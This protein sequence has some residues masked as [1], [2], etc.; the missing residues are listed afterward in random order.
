MKNKFMIKVN[1]FIAAVLVLYCFST[2]GQSEKIFPLGYNPVIKQA[3]SS[4]V[5]SASSNKTSVAND[6]LTLPFFDDFSSLTI[7]PD[8]QRWMDSLAFVN[9]NFP[10]NPPTLGVATFDGL[11]ANGNPYDN[12]STAAK[13]LCDELTSKP[14][15]LFKDE[16]GLPYNTSDSIFL[17]YYYQRK[18]WGDAPELADSLVLQFYSPVTGIWESVWSVTGGSS[19][20]IFTKAKISIDDTDYRQVGFQF[21]FRNYGSKTGNLDIWNVDYISLRKFLPPDYENIRDFAFVNQGKSLL[22]IYSSVPWKH[23][24]QLPSS[25]QQMMMKTSAD[26]T[27]RNNNEANPFPIKV[28]GNIKDQYGNTTQ[29]IGGGGLNSIQIPLNTNVTPPAPINNNY[30][31]QDPTLGDSATFEAI[32]DLGQTSGGVVD[33]YSQNDTMRYKQRLYNYYA[34]D[35]GTAELGYGVSGIG[36]Q[37]AYKFELLA[38]DTLRA[39][40]MFFTQIGT[41]VTN[42]IFRIAVWTGANSP[43]GSPIYE[44]FNQSPNYSDSINGFYTY[45]TDDIYLSAGTYY[46][47]WIQNL[48]TILNLGLD[49]NTEVDASRKF[50]NTTGSWT[51]SALPGAWMIRPVFSSTPID[52]GIEDINDQNSL[53]VYPNPATELLNIKLP[54]AFGTNNEY[55]ITDITGRKFMQDKFLG[56]PI[57]ISELQNGI[58]FIT[59]YNSVNGSSIT[60]RFAVSR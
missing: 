43:S 29:I 3:L 24:A 48:S 54:V 7:W 12:S 13:G 34:Y 36:A 6:T 20:T 2:F 10:I 19:D 26:L 39:V 56:D 31:F 46:F 40:Q 38:P 18:G 60:Q 23:Y 35:D 33:D 5:Q 14:L 21:R 8:Q 11:D 49:I 17:V 44:K 32:Y 57:N 47:G 50:Y 59:I 45:L 9:Y 28:A 1:S 16:N 22:N 53:V 27:V 51:N 37:L 4:K 41:S 25:Q 30:Y 58:Y 52:V 42:R 55:Q 15:D